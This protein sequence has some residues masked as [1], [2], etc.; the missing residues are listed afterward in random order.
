MRTKIALLIFGFFPAV[1]WAQ[2][3]V[4][5]SMTPAQLVQNILVGGGVN[6]SN[7]TYTGPNGAIGS[8]TNGQTTNLGLQSGILLSTGGITN[9]PNP[10]SYFL[11]NSLGGNGDAQLEQLSGGYTSYDAVVLEFDFVPQSTPVQFR[12]VFGSE[13]YPEYVCS[14][15]NDAFGFFV[16]GQ[17]PQGGNYNNQNIALIPNTTIPVTINSV[18]SGQVGSYGS[19]S[20]C[21]SLSYSSYYVNNTNGTTICFDGFT[22]VLTARL[23]VVPCQ[24][25]HIKIAVSDIG[26]G[27]YDSGVFLEANSFQSDAINVASYYTNPALGLHAIESCS[28]SIV[29]FTLNHPATQPVTVNYTIG[30]TAT[31][32]VDYTTIP[33]SLTIPVGSD[34]VGL[35]IHPIMDGQAEGNETVTFIVQTSPCATDTI[36]VTI[37]DNSPLQATVSND[38]TICDGQQPVAF[39]VTGSGGVSPLTYNWSGGLGTSPNVSISPP[40]G[41]YNY[42]VT[43]T[44]AC[45]A[46]AT[47][48]I[49]VV[50][51]PKPTSDFT[52]VTPICAG[53]PSDVVYTGTGG[54]T[55]V[56]NF[57]SATILSGTPPSPGPYQVTWNTAGTYAIALQV[58]N[59][60]GCWSD[61]DTQYVMVLAAGT[62]NCCT[63]PTPFAGN[64]RNVCG[65]TTQMMADPPDNPSY[66]GQ[67]TQIN[68]PG[69]STFG[70]PSAFNSSV[71]V[72]QAGTYTYEWKE[73][74]G[75]CD[76]TDYVQITF[77]A[78]PVP[79][80]GPDTSVCG[81]QYTMQAVLSTPGTGSWTGVGISSPTNPNTNVIVPTY[82]PY[83]YVWTETNNGCT[84]K[85]T[86]IINFLVVPTPNAGV[87][88]TA[89]GNRAILVADSTYSGYW[90]G[91]NGV[92]YV[93]GD[94]SATTPIFIPNYTGSQYTATFTWHEVNGPCTASDNVQITF[95]RP[96]HA[97][98]GNNTISVCGTSVTLAADTIG[99]GVT[100]GYWY[101]VPSGPVIT[102]TGLV[103]F[104]ATVDISSMGSNAYHYS[105][106]EFYLYW[107][108]SNGQCTNYDSVKV[109]FYDIPVAYAGL[110]TAICGNSYYLAASW[111]I[112]NPVGLWSQLSGP[113][114]ATFVYPTHKNTMVS[115][116]QFG[117]YQFIWKEMNAGNTSCYSTDTITI[118]FKVTPM[119]DAG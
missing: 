14:Q 104:N 21:T 105:V 106:G 83:T 88:T 89:C 39:N 34:S 22:T 109:N 13:E 98:A 73:I 49:Q 84:A 90:T 3:Q 100:S 2:L 17:N 8:F 38:I 5:G 43:V 24:P 57:G 37:V 111:S 63:F 112:D 30:G 11:S 65:L 69:I 71:T 16:S 78:M 18:N 9:V 15:F 62:P 25:Y 41:S 46:T 119:P 54:S 53:T 70:M 61:P 7:I 85:D 64:D 80:A 99:S 91:P 56:W 31:N 40:V 101:S 81:L 87:D 58:Q 27:I 60:Y 74:N 107:V 67:W 117:V 50:V 23:D 35:I 36:V 47:D 55:F 29:S 1:L 59:T 4:N 82:G 20:N 6:V 92:I 77:I 79:N 33:S 86:V 113:G 108:V 76:S 48:G 52:A 32:G 114:T 26:D 45:G 19:S 96:P 102:Q 110:D 95:I 12:Y 10:G 42:T 51:N 44:D 66:V 115:V 118:N 94:T 93:Y 75:P 72:T 28:N 97:E 103:P 68:G 116:T